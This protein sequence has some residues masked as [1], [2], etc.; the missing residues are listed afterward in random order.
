[1]LSQTLSFSSDKSESESLSFDIDNSEK[2]K[3][4]PLGKQY[5]KSEI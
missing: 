1:M 4:S 3:Q 5:S 2:S